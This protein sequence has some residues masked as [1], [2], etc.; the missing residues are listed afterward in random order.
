MAV[1]AREADDIWVFGIGSLDEPIPNT[2]LRVYL[3]YGWR[4]AAAYML[5]T[6]HPRVWSGQVASCLM[7]VLYGDVV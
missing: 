4:P 2:H 6:W 1:L 5:A 7:F 3:A